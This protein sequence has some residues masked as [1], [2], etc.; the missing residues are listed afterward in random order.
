[1]V[2]FHRCL[3]VNRGEVGTPASGPRSL[4]WRGRG[5]GSTSQDRGTPPPTKIGVT[6]PPPRLDKR[7]SACYAAGSTAHAVTQEVCLLN[8]NLTSLLPG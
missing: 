1:M 2:I 6:P 5:G 4:L 8:L 7:A 3:S